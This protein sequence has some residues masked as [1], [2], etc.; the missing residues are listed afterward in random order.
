MAHGSYTC[1][2]FCKSDNMA[3]FQFFSAGAHIFNLSEGN[4]SPHHVIRVCPP[5]QSASKKHNQEKKSIYLCAPREFP[6]NCLPCLIIIQSCYFDCRISKLFSTSHCVICVSC[7]VHL[8]STNY[9][10]KGSWP[11]Y[12]K[13]FSNGY[14]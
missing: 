13:Y 6:K 4:P 11:F 1:K 7:S 2:T 5:S 3:F 9:V 8:N 14:H 10:R 12:L